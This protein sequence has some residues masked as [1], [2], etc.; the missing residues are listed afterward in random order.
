[1]N[2]VSVERSDWTGC[3][4]NK[5]GSGPKLIVRAAAP[6]RRSV[7]FSTQYWTPRYD[8]FPLVHEEKS[9]AE[10]RTTR[11]VKP[12]SGWS[13]QPVIVDT[14]Y[15]FQEPVE[16]FV[17]EI[18]SNTL[19]DVTSAI[20]AN[21]RPLAVSKWTFGSLMKSV[22]GTPKN[23][24]SGKVCTSTPCLVEIRPR[25]FTISTTWW[26]PTATWTSGGVRRFVYRPFVP[27][28][29]PSKPSTG[30]AAS[31]GRGD[32]PAWTGRFRRS[33]PAAMELNVDAEVTCG[34]A[35]NVAWRGLSSRDWIAVAEFDIA[36]AI[37]SPTTTESARMSRHGWGNAMLA[38]RWREPGLNPLPKLADGR[39]S[40][41]QWTVGVVRRTRRRDARAGIR[42]QV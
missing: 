23:V 2:C 25:T 21:Q 19:P 5:V 38:E 8:G 15:A 13:A 12:R 14:R 29:R 33:P 31:G 39:N 16:S 10:M 18:S 35:G 11:S 30:T 7:L 6:L 28:W 4:E 41:P 27:K 32:G 24:E 1:M 34:S 36:G 17:A 42:T 37:A 3:T 9:F 26:G 22:D 40:L 20:E